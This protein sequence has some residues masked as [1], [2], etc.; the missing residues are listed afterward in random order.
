MTVDHALEGVFQEPLRIKHGKIAVPERPGIGIEVDL[1]AIELAHSLHKQH[2][3]G[4]CDD[5]IA[6]Q[7]LIPAGRSTISVLALCD[8]AMGL[9]RWFDFALWFLRSPLFSGRPVALV[10]TPIVRGIPAVS[11]GKILTT[12]HR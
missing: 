11:A 2:G 9:R 6:V 5:A 1:A 10:V 8:R 12:K 7:F 3:L 4:A